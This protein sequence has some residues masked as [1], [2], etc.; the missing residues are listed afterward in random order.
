MYFILDINNVIFN[1][2]SKLE[3][4]IVQLYKLS[5]LSNNCK[6]KAFDAGSI[7]GIYYVNN[8][9]IFYKTKKDNDVVIYEFKDIPFELMNVSENIQEN[10]QENKSKNIYT[11]KTY[12]NRPRHISSDINVQLPPINTEILI[13]SNDNQSEKPV[14]LEKLKRKIEELNKLKELEIGDLENLN[15]NL[16]EYENKIIA[17]KFNVDAEKNKLKRDK[18]KWDEFKNIFNADKKI[19]RIMKEQFDRSEIDEIPELFEKKYPIFKVLDENNLLDTTSEIYEYIKLL[20]DDDSVY[21]PKDI[22]LNGLFNKDNVVS[23][24]S[25]TE[26]KEM[27]IETTIETDDES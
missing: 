26:L 11:R 4:S 8:N 7:V 16:H 22:V 23:S 24:I 25:L 2:Y 18:E 19:Y 12:N 20:P 27:N 10:I 9:K 13:T 17:E 15:E 6:L 14:D 1:I 3:G 5:E 21:I